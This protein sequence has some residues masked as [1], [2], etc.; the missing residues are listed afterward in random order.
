MRRCSPGDGGE[1]DAIANDG[2]DVPAVPDACAAC[3]LRGSCEAVRDP[4]V[5]A[6]GEL[7]QTR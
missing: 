7:G 4:D 2:A 3:V 5:R 6:H 1:C